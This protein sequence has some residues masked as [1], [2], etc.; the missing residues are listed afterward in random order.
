LRVGAC[1]GRGVFD[2]R[3]SFAALAVFAGF[4]GT[5]LPSGVGGDCWRPC[6]PDARGFDAG[7]RTSAGLARLSAG[8]FSAVVRAR[9]FAMVPLLRAACAPKRHQ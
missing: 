2:V 3:F 5:G 8:R 9:I 6:A 7:R 4:V 1:S